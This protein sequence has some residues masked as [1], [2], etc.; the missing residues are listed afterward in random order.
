[1]LNKISELESSTFV[2]SLAR[3]VLEKEIDGL[4]ALKSWFCDDFI[5]VVDRIANLKGRVIV[6]GMGK[7]GHIARKIASTLSSTGTPALFVHPAEASHG[8]LGMIT[9]DDLVILLSNSGESEELNNILDYCK[10]FL[11][12]VVGIS[13]KN[14]STLTLASEIA[15]VLPDTPEASNI[16]APTT[17]TTMMIAL[18]DALAVVL[19]EKRGFTH[20]DFKILH[21]GGK[22]GSKLIKVKELMHS[23]E[24]M[25]LAYNDEP[26]IK[27]IIEMTIKRLGCVGVID[28]QEGV[29]LGVFTDGDLRR[30]IDHDFKMVKIEE[31]MTKNPKVIT[32]EAFASEALGIMNKKAITNLFVIEDKKPLG[33]IHMH[34]ILRAKIV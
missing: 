29:L 21:P 33:V 6:S 20:S 23:G 11:I 25:P 13:R 4:H 28:K 30:H 3:K 24:S 19:Y 12:P 5:Q 31:I 15:L 16:S 10:R 2:L 17:S 18:G 27:A 22:I 14:N 26:A 1:M 34:D 32:K 7:S 8:D 9:E